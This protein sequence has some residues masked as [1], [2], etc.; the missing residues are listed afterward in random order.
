MSNIAVQRDNANQPSLPARFAARDWDPFRAMRDLIRWEPFAELA[1]SFGAFDN[2]V[3]SPAFEVKETKEGFFFRADV[4]GVK[5]ADLDVKLTQNRL[6]V[7][8]KRE[9]EKTEKGDTFYTSERSYGSFS[10]SFTLPD[11][12]DTDKIRAELKEGVLTLSIP[13]KPEIQPKKIAITN[14]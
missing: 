12:V 11:G 14:K 8:G 2:A 5:D 6:S 4:P 3:F 10:R 13:K 1:P 7:S 9:S